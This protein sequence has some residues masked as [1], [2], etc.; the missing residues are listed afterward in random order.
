MSASWFSIAY[1][2][3]NLF[4]SNA[5]GWDSGK[6]LPYSWSRSLK[7]QQVEVMFDR[8]S[9]R[10][11]A[12]NRLI[13]FGIDLRWRTNLIRM[14]KAEKPTHV[15]DVATGT[16]DLALGLA[17]ELHSARIVGLDISEG[18]LRRARLKAKQKG[19]QK[20]V[21]FVLGDGEWLP[22]SGGSFDAVT[23]AFGVRNFAHLRRGLGELY[24]VLRADGTLY[25]LE[26][27]M[28]TSPLLRHFY[29]IYTH[30]V[31]PWMA[32]IFS[33]DKHAYRYLARSASKFPHGSAFAGI[34]SNLWFRNTTVH[35]Q[36]MGVA[37]IYRATRPSV[38]SR[39]CS[40]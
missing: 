1:F 18:M 23:V 19:L 24:R 9:D 33:K 6:V 36:T 27:S 7:K 25:V 22:F 29:R 4:L 11:D 2:A 30:N 39:L 31:M 38:W 28:P 34:L 10:Y 3:S 37:T 21:D 8:I 14:V 12:L 15:L 5:S 32:N 35:P 40:W 17:R 13:T 16:G 26:T 20:R